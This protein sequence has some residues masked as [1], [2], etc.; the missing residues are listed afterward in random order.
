MAIKIV[1]TVNRISPSASIA[2]TSNPI[3]MKSGYLRVSTAST[4][5]FITVG[6]DPVAIS[7]SFHLPP[8]GTEV[9]KERFVKQRISGITTGTT[10]ILDF[11]DLNGHA[12]SMEDRV[13]IENGYPIGI[14]TIH[15]SILSLTDTTV[16]LNYNSSA[17]TGIAITSAVATRSV[18]VSAL[19]DGA[20]TN[21]SITEVVQ[22]VSE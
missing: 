18:K 3:S 22:L 2:S 10:T 16:T 14:N 13:T 21:V 9:L 17:L 15:S 5:A 4:G 6:A 8:Y 19:G 20:G 11:S 7:N 12:F 1:Q